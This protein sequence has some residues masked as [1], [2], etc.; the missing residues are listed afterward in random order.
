[1]KLLWK[2]DYNNILFVRLN[3]STYWKIQIF[4]IEDASN[5]YMADFMLVR[6]YI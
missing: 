3:S 6:I 5:T 4:R 1:M 2:Q